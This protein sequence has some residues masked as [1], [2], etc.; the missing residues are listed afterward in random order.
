MVYNPARRLPR[1]SFNGIT[2]LGV[3]IGGIP[4]VGE[5]YQGGYNRV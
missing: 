2:R 1:A 5:V 3:C 4:M